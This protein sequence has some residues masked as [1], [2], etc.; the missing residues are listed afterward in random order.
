MRVTKKRIEKEV[1]IAM[2]EIRYAN[3]GLPYRP[4]LMGWDLIV[5]PN[6]FVNGLVLLTL[7]IHYL[8]GDSKKGAYNIAM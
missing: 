5:T 2:R 1:R 7:Q 4:K 8:D 6:S 3:K